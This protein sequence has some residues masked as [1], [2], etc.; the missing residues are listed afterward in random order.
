MVLSKEPKKTHHF[1]IKF[2]IDKP[3]EYTFG[4]HMSGP[5]YLMNRTT[6][7]EVVN[8]STTPKVGTIKTMSDVVNQDL[9]GKNE[10]SGSE[11]D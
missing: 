9:I 10:C 4:W 2:E 8:F 5:D 6:T 3:G 11:R 7:F 1:I